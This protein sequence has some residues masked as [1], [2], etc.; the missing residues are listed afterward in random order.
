MSETIEQMMN[1]QRK[2]L[3]PR[4]APNGL[5][6]PRFHIITEVVMNTVDDQRKPL[7]L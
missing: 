2:E 3:P 1:A 4:V 5:E 6:L 7:S